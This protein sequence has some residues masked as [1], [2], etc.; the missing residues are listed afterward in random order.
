MDEVDVTILGGGAAGL[1]L[2]SALVASDTPPETIRIV[3]PRTAYQRDRTWCFW[4]HEAPLHPEAIA[5]RWPAWNVRYGGRTARRS[6]RYDYVEIPANRF[7]EPRS[8]AFHA[9]RA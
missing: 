1:S 6:G 3:E 7:Y 8:T 2:A 9:T 5:H 4:D